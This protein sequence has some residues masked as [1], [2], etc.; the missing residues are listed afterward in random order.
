[1]TLTLLPYFLDLTVLDVFRG[2]I[3]ILLFCCL[4]EYD[5][6]NIDLGVDD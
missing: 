3:Y 2:F 1:M 4:S 6:L 5:E